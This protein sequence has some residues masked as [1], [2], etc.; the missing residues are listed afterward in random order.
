MSKKLIT[1]CMALF[2][3]AAF[4]LPA[5]AS[6]A[7]NVELTHPTGTKLAAGVKIKGTNVGNTIFQA[8]II[9]VECST[10]VFT[11]VLNRNNEEF[12]SGSGT[13][14]TEG[15][16]ETATFSGTGTGTPGDCTPNSFPGPYKVTTNV[17]NGVPFCL[18]THDTFNADEVKLKGNSCSSPTERNITFVLHATS[19]GK[20]C[21]YIRHL[22]TETR[23]SGTGTGPGPIIGSYDTDTPANNNSDAIITLKNSG[24]NTTFEGEKTND[25]SCPGNGFLEMSVTLETDEATAKPLYFS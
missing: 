8:G 6:A 14:R 5:S 2:A 21:K 17:G 16:I 20:E 22:T 12:P 23:E 11:G 24:E 4:A 3:L 1:A 13:H 15:T 19:L 10:A 7:T 18:F 9:K 25:F